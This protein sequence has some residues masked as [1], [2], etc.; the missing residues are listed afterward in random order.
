ME[1]S[2]AGAAGPWTDAGSLFAGPAAPTAT[3][4]P[5]P[6]AF[7]NPLG[8]RSA[9]VRESNGYGCSRADLSS[10]AGQNVM[11][12][13]RIGTDQL[14]DDYG[15]FLDDIRIVTC[16]AAGHHA[17]TDDHHQAPEEEDL[18]PQGEVRLQVQ[19][20]RLDVQVQAGQ[21]EVEV[22]LVAQEVQEP[23]DREAQVPG[24]RD[25]RRRQRRP[26]ASRV[27]VEDQALAARVADRVRRPHPR[28]VVQ[29]TAHAAR[30]LSLR[31]LPSAPR[32]GRCAP[33]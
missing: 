19:R 29:L 15:W 8:G 11:F 28:G 16:G 3:R 25:R 33:R 14:F 24:L 30:E 31:R 21:E 20:A 12:R 6:R 1:Y 17:A 9:F 4:A 13:W 5:S 23:Q 2:T 18:Q 32:R 7:R 10:L 26:D 27:E 22:L